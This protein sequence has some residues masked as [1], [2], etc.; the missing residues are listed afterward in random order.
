M[1]KI[2]FAGILLVSLATLAIS[3]FAIRP[4]LD[5]LVEGTFTCPEDQRYCFLELWRDGRLAGRRRM[6]SG[7]TIDVKLLGMD[8]CTE[9]FLD[10]KTCRGKNVFG[11]YQDENCKVRWELV[12]ECDSRCED[13]ACVADQTTTTTTTTTSSIETTTTTTTE[14]PKKTETVSCEELVGTCVPKAS[15]ISCEYS[16]QKTED[17]KNTERCCV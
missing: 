2:L 15:F 17:C 9:G 10:E 16:Y 5:L 14:M 4:M 12:E 13:G 11:E 7:E 6:V 8:K 1:K 3:A